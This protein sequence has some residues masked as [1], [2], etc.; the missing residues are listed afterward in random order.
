MGVDIRKQIITGAIYSYKELG[1]EFV[2]NYFMNEPDK[3]GD[4]EL[5]QLNPYG[6][7]QLPDFI[8]G[9][10]DE[11]LSGDGDRAQQ[12]D[13]SLL[14]KV[15]LNEESKNLVSETIVSNN[16]PERSVDTYKV[17]FFT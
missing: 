9:K 14:E 1:E 12:G 10:V 6:S 13:A 8:L 5:I 17:I 4:I 15:E 2:D 3:F 11:V 16:L 7:E